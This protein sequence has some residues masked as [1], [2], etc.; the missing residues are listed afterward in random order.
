MGMI[1]PE[2]ATKLPYNPQKTCPNCGV[3]LTEA[4]EDDED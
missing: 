4:F 2:C 3:D 1:C